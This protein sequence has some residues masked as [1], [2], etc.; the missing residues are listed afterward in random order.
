MSNTNNK[1]V[2]E[3]KNIRR[4]RGEK[5]LYLYA[6]LCKDGQPL[7]HATLDYIHE[8]LRK[9]TV[10]DYKEEIENQGLSKE[11]CLHG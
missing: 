5:V 9:L 6:E 2:Y 1:P 8:R 3:I 11:D 4:G 7:I 10:E